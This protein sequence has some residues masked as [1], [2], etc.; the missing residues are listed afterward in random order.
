VVFKGNAV[1]EGRIWI[2]GNVGVVVWWA[3]VCGM[4]KGVCVCGT[5]R[6]GGGLNLL[7]V[8]DVKV[9]LGYVN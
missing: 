2:S 3:A 5:K 6:P 4:G 9:G 8:I 7:R 1:V